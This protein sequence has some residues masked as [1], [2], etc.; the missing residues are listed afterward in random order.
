MLQ[1]EKTPLEGVRARS[2]ERSDDAV[3]PVVKQALTLSSL[4]EGEEQ[5]ACDAN[6]SLQTKS[7]EQILPSSKTTYKQSMPLGCPYEVAEG[8]W[9]ARATA[10]IREWMNTHSAIVDECSR[11][12]QKILPV[13][14]TISRSLVRLSAAQMGQ[15]LN[16][17]R[18]KLSIVL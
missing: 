10:Y 17:A 14:K 16:G 12:V 1:S 18:P 7:K 2:R 9:L 8:M 5:R 11:C 13:T 15:M 4:K 6:I 3:W